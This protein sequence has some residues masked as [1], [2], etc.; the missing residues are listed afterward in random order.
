VPKVSPTHEQR[1]REQIL[2]AALACFA[3]QGYHTTSIGDIVRESG[4]SVGA[5]YTY[6]PAKEELFL[7]VASRRTQQALGRLKQL[8]QQPGGI[9]DKAEDAA[10]VFFDQLQDELGSYA[11]VSS[12][13]WNAATLSEQLQRQREWLCESVRGFVRELLSE[14]KRR[15]EIRQDVD[16]PAMTELIMALNDGL[17]LH[18]ASGLQPV[19]LSALKRAYVDFLTRGLEPLRADATTRGA[20]GDGVQ[21][22]RTAGHRGTSLAP[23][24]ATGPGMQDSGGLHNDRP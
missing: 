3:R 21:S 14:A 18:H 24:S 19:A 6:Y 10:T 22:L 13:F 1:R 15:G 2:D 4:L 23:L 5:L 9:V 16:I 12:E 11:R 8:F 17:L 20:A 7:A